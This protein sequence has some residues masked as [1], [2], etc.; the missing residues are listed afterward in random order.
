MKEKCDDNTVETK[1][2]I[3]EITRLTDEWYFLIA[4]DHHKDR[5]CHWYIETKWSYGHEPIY[6]LQHYGYIIHPDI[7]ISYKSYEQALVNMKKLL[8]QHIDDEKRSQ[9]E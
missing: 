1:K 6:T 8:E 4:K 9:K 2:L 7:N 5:D 3:D